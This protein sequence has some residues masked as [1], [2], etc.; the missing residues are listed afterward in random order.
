MWRIA[1]VA[2]L[3]S[4]DADEFGY[5]HFL[6]L[7]IDQS[8]LFIGMFVAVIASAFYAVTTRRRPPQ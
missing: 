4:C 5:V 2:L 6:G 7:E 3:S 1:V 8:A